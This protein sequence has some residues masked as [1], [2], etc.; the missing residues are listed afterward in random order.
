MPIS[1]NIAFAPALF[2]AE[3][4]GIAVLDTV[5]TSSFLLSPIPKVFKAI[6]KASVPLPTAIPYLNLLYFKKLFS[7]YSSCLPKKSS[8]DFKVLSIEFKIFFLKYL[9]SSTKDQVFIIL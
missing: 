4:V 6:S 9:Y 8:P 2:I 3:T 5:I 1:T 7:N